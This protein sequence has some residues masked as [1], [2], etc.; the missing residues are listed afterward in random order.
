MDAKD[1]RLEERLAD[2]LKQTAEV[3]A[4]IQAV[5]QGGR[6]PHYDEIELPA[7]EVGQRLS[8][9][10]QASRTGDVAADQQFQAKCP[11]CGDLCRVETQRREVHS[12]DGPVELL[13][14][15]AHCRRCRRSFFPSA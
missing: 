1:D 12:M 4:R 9:M 13:E 5:Q 3:A 6:T 14:T 15:V 2:L 10:I 7:H 8:R 11:D